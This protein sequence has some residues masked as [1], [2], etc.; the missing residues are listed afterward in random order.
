MVEEKMGRC[1]G[2]VIDCSKFGS[3]EKLLQVTCFVRRFA[4]NLKAK[5][6]GS[7]GLQGSLSVAEMEKW[8][9]LVEVW[10]THYGARGYL[11]E[12]TALVEFNLRWTFLL[13]LKIVFSEFDNISTSRKWPLL[14]R[15]HSNF[16]NL[17]MRDGHKK[18]FHNGINSTLNFLSNKYYLIRGRPSTKSLLRKCVSCKYINTKIVTPPATLPLPKFRLNYTFPYQNIGLGYAG[19]IYFKSCDLTEKMAEDYF[20]ITTCCCTCAVHIELTTDIFI[21]LF[22]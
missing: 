19:L 4:L 21:K 7:Q 13:R 8:E 9:V 5:Q 14:L 12:S 22:Y 18:N 2:E 15:S 17:G 20:L 10:T 1:I 3:L 16:T 11:L 6:M